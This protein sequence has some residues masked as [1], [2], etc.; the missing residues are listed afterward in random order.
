MPVTIAVRLTTP[1][2]LSVYSNSRERRTGLERD[3]VI[4][5]RLKDSGD[6]R[7]CTWVW[8]GGWG[9]DLGAIVTCLT[10]VNGLCG[11]VS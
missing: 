8:M 9:Y 7:V 4:G 5:C 3:M 1:T 2:W 11:Q 10:I 6:E